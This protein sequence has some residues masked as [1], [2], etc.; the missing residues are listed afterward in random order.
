MKGVDVLLI[1]K[2]GRRWHSDGPGRLA[3]L[4]SPPAAAREV[5]R[6]VAPQLR[7]EAELPVQVGLHR[8]AR[9]VGAFVGPAVAV[10]ARAQQPLPRRFQR[11][12]AATQAAVPP[13]SAATGAVGQP[14]QVGAA[15]ARQPCRRHR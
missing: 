15:M 10:D 7:D 6:A 8:F 9:G 3:G 5:V 13:A 12:P 14:R 1:A 11:A 2:D 4:I